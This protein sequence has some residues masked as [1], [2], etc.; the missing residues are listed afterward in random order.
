MTHHFRADS[1]A[2]TQ[3]LDVFL[4]NR[5]GV[6][7]SQAQ[8]LLKAQGVT[9]NSQFERPSYSMR[10]DEDVVVNEPIV[11]RSNHVAPDLP[12]V[13]EDPDLLIVDK[14]AGLA[15]HPGAGLNS[16]ATVADFARGRTV[17]TDPDRPG[18]VH[19]LDRDTSGLLIIAKTTAAKTYLQ[20]AF[21][22]REIH[23]VYLLLA[24]GRV[25]PDTAVI[26]LPVGRNPAHPLRQ[27]VVSGGRESMTAYKTVADYPGY[28][29]IE[30]R[31]QTGRTHQLRVH[32][33][34]LGHPVAGDTSYGP[35][36][37]PLGLKRHFLHATALEFVS[38]SGTPLVLA[39]PLPADL[40]L[41]LDRLN[42]GV[43]S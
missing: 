22:N 3:R 18:I 30:A 8:Q 43:A 32:F 7:R 31:P 6:S 23:K 27:A 40:Q 39:S 36:R 13:F 11:A 35:P 21:K 16:S 26:R 5:L 29:L 12:I 17:D 19:R 37:R 14:P 9:V 33:A 10:G 42:A 34:A 25:S 38:P 4:A 24:T 1:G 28:S 15:V 2:A 41:V 20:K